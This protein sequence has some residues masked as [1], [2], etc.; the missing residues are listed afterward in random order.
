MDDIRI[1]DIHYKDPKLI[2]QISEGM[3]KIK[4]ICN[5]ESDVL[6]HLFR[7]EYGLYVT[8]ISA[9]I[10]R[11]DFFVQAQA[12]SYI[13]A[14]RLAKKRLLHQLLK[15]KGRL[16]SVRHMPQHLWP[17]VT[18]AEIKYKEGA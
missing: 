7:N 2:A 1:D 10:Y 6:I 15:Q 8:D 12:H 16:W 18:P 14:F 3:R 9:H 13:A 5:A 11:R 17:E 4:K